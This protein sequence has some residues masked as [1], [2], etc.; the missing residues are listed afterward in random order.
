M[1]TV[2]PEAPSQPA[3]DQE[4]SP[5]AL[6]SALLAGWR[7][8][9][10]AALV[11]VGVAAATTAGR[12]PTYTTTAT[13]VLASAA[14]GSPLRG[15][16]TQ[17]GVGIPSAG[18]GEINPE[19]VALVA[20][21]PGIQRRLALDSLLVP[22]AGA[23]KQA[24]TDLLRRGKPPVGDSVAAERHVRGVMS[25]LSSM[26]TVS[27]DRRTNAIY[28]VASAPW[29]SMALQ[30]A[31]RTTASLNQYLLELRKQRA[32]LERQSIEERLAQQEQRLRQEEERLA[33]FLQRNRLYQAASDL[34]F[35]FDR[36]QR[37]VALQQQV[38][39]SLA[40]SREEVLSREMQAVPTIT[41]LQPPL[42][43]LSPAPSK[44][45]QTLA[46]GLFAGAV[47]GALWVL[48]S[49][50]LRTALAADTPE[51]RALREQLR[52]MRPRRPASPNSTAS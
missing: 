35:E 26:V 48:A 36:L 11:G 49:N 43:P 14:G 10:L 41:V 22:E 12:K 52:A 23:G 38:L 7:Q 19:L 21:S 46:V 4:F 45:T 40:Q 5:L 3:D 33:A 20:G 37:G 6:V 27:A 50:A 44:R 31:Q 42:A 16:A 17:L 29:P 13:L 8:V 30:L 18:G 39:V 1:T 47:L 9:L 28:L 51:V 25:A 15:A 32:S 34:R 24:V 2:T